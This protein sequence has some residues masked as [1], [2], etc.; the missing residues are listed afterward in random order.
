MEVSVWVNVC[1]SVLH[2]HRCCMYTGVACTQVLHVH[3][4]VSVSGDVCGDAFECVTM[5]LLATA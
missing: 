4:S 5:R 2:V 1:E 3:G